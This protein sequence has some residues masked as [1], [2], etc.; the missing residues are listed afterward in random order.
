MD[1]HLLRY[2]ETKTYT[3]IDCET[4][5]LCL[6]PC[7]NLPW[8]VG[9]IKCVGEKVQATKDFYVK[10]DR[11]INVGKEAARITG[12]SKKAYEKRALHIKEIFP[13]IEDW[14]DDCDYILGH[15][16]LGFDIYLIKAIY[17]YSGKSWVHLVPKILDTN[18]IARGIKNGIP[19]DPRDESFTEYQYKMLNKRTKGIKTNLKSLGLEYDIEHEYDKLHDAVVDLELNFKVWN[20]LKWQV[21][22]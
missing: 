20:K 5:N 7:N 12:F 10:W 9:M 19:F 4:E 11:E 1:E 21:E 13:T 18:S 6:N 14:L 15:N 3:L 17:E 16:I 8:Q 22:I 2:D